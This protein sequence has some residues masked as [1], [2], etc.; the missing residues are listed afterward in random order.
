MS[1][2]RGRK[3]LT[4]HRRNGDCFANLGAAVRPLSTRHTD[5]RP[6]GHHVSGR[7]RHHPSNPVCSDAGAHK[8]S[9]P[10]VRLSNPRRVLCDNLYARPAVS[11]RSR[12]ARPH[13]PQRIRPN[14]G[15]GMETIG[16]LAGRGGAGCICRDAQSYAW[17]RVSRAGKCGGCISTR[18]RPEG[19]TKFKYVWRRPWRKCRGDRHHGHDLT[20]FGPRSS[21]HVRGKTADAQQEESRNGPSEESLSSMIGGFKAAVTTRIREAHSDSD[22]SVWQSRYYDRILRNE[23]EWRA[24]REY[25]ARNPGRWADD[26]H[27]PYR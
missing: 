7:V 11:L 5:V 6:S 16:G 2:I 13:V 9:S 25:S 19:W 18:I 21:L 26:R 22:V 3:R 15:G 10:V 4:P 20:T 17:D 12:A 1:W 8:S 27:H 14:C 23:R 24:C